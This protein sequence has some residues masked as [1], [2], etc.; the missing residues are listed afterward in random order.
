MTVKPYYRNLIDPLG[1]VSEKFLL[2]WKKKNKQKD[3]RIKEN[4]MRIADS[5][6]SDKFIHNF[7]NS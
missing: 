2:E 3:L 4:N 6:L 1:L 7:S 5:I